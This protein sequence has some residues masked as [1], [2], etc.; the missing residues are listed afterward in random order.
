MAALADPG[1]ASRA[2]L[3]REARAGGGV[4]ARAVEQWRRWWKR[5]RGFARHSI[6]RR[7]RA[8]ACREGGGG[9]AARVE[10]ARGFA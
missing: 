10:K 9:V 6:V 2:A 8:V 3:D 4:F 5:G 1:C 7:G